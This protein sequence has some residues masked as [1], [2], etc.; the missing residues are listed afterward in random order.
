[1]SG[2]INTPLNE[3]ATA[4]THD[5][6]P[7]RLQLMMINH[8]TGEIVAEGPAA[9]GG[10]DLSG[11]STGSIIPAVVAPTVDGLTGGTSNTVGIP[12]MSEWLVPIETINTGTD[13]LFNVVLSINFFDVKGGGPTDVTIPFTADDILSSAI[14]AGDQG[15]G[16]IGSWFPLLTASGVSDYLNAYLG[17][18]LTAVNIECAETVAGTF[19]DSNGLTWTLDPTDCNLSMGINNGDS[20]EVDPLLEFSG[21]LPGWT[22]GSNAATPGLAYTIENDGEEVPSV[23]KLW[24]AMTPVGITTYDVSVNID[25][26]T[27]A[28]N[29]VSGSGTQSGEADINIGALPSLDGVPEG[30]S[31]LI[32]GAITWAVTN[33]YTDSVGSNPPGL[34]GGTINAEFYNVTLGHQTGIFGPVSIVE[35]SQSGD[36]G[37]QVG[38]EEIDSSAIVKVFPTALEP[39]ASPAYW[40]TLLYTEPYELRLRDRW[41]FNI[42]FNLLNRTEPLS[43][44]DTVHVMLECSID[45]ELWFEEAFVY[46]GVSYPS[47]ENTTMAVQ[48]VQNSLAAL[49][50]DRPPNV[51]TITIYPTETSNTRGPWNFARLLFYVDTPDAWENIF[52]VVTAVAREL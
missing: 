16:G 46:A 29:L 43:D 19:V 34:T 15:L 35:G 28:A 45:G 18:E 48:L 1:M 23:P 17:D 9:P 22:V 52:S 36:D 13:I 5:S 51:G 30:A 39:D 44:S 32:A 33:P 20:A 11:A 40:A 27:I 26:P 24:L 42:W 31:W 37:D 14:A 10:I 3:C 2:N 25:G 12:I 47:M 21:N 49:S 4:I 8:D 38:G 6:D 50:P 41:A 7:R